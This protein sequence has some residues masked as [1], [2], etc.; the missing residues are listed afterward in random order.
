VAPPRRR[1]RVLKALAIAAG[2]V[3]LVLVLV[4]LGLFPQGWLQR[5]AERQILAALGPGSRIGHLHVIPGRLRAEA[6]DVLIV[7]PG[8]RV[9]VKDARVELALSTLLGRAFALRS[10][11]LRDPRI[12]IEPTPAV[13]GAAAP[14]GTPPP[15]TRP[16]LLGD[17]DVT[18]GQVRYHNPQLGGDIHVEDVRLTGGVGKGALHLQTGT[19][20]WD[21]PH[22]VV[23]E[24]VTATVSITSALVAHLDALEVA[25]RLSHLSAS[26]SLGK[27]TALQPDVEIRLALDIEDAKT[28]APG[29]AM[30][31]QVTGDAHVKG[32]GATLHADANLQGHALTIADR[33]IERARV[34]AVY[35]A[36]GMRADAD[37]E[38]M[39]GRIAATA[40]MNGDQISAD[41][42]GTDLDLHRAAVFAQTPAGA[43][44]GRVSLQASAHG[45]A[46]ERLDTAVNLDASGTD[47]DLAF[48]ARLEAS[49]PIEGSDH[50]LGI[51]WRANG[52]A[53]Q[54]ARPGQPTLQQSTWTADGSANGAWPAVITGQLNGAG[55]FVSATGASAFALDGHG[56]AH[57]ADVAAALDLTGDVGRVHVDVT[58]GAADQRIDVSAQ[59]VALAR[60]VPET[61]GIVDITYHGSGQGAAFHGAGQAQVADLTWRTVHVGA[62][63]ASITSQGD[64]TQVIGDSP[65][66]RL[67]ATAS[68]APPA[69]GRE[70]ALTA[71][72]Q[73][74][75]TPLDQVS[76]FI[77]GERTV[78]GRVRGTLT[79]AAPVKAL[80]DATVQGHIEVLELAADP[81]RGATAHPF[82]LEMS[83]TRLAVRDFSFRGPGVDVETS[84][85]FDFGGRATVDAA[86]DAHLDLSK[87]PLPPGYTMT[88]STQAAVVLSG[89]RDRPQIHGHVD[90]AQLSAAG[91]ALPPF[92]IASARLVLDHDAV[93]LPETVASFARGQVHLAGSAPVAAFWAAPSRA[94]A[95]ARVDVRWDGIDV[96]ALQ[97]TADEPLTGTVDGEAHLQGSWRDP[98][99]A[100]LTLHMPAL[101]LAIGDMP[102]ALTPIDADL[103]ERKLTVAPFEIGSEQGAVR[104]TASADLGRRTIAGSVTGD[105]DLRILSPFM[106]SGSLAGNAQV[107]LSVS[108]PMAAPQTKGHLA[109]HD[110]VVRMREITTPLTD[111]DGT[112]TFDGTRVQIASMEARWGGGPLTLSGSARIDKK[113]LSDMHVEAKGEELAVR[114]QDIQTRVN[115]DLI[116]SGHTGDL[117]LSGSVD[118]ERGLFDRDIFLGQSLRETAA[119]ET[120][121]PFL[122]T[123]GLDLKINTTE[124]FLVRNNLAQVQARGNLRLRGDAQNPAPF[125]TFKIAENG[126]VFIQEREFRIDSGSITYVGSLDPNL[127]IQA[128]TTKPVPWQEGAGSAPR[129][130]EA[131][132]TVHVTGDLARPA[133]ALS[134]DADDLSSTEI[135]S[136]LATGR[137]DPGRDRGAWLVGEQA[138]ELLAG[139]LSR[140]LSRKL[141]SLG[142]DQVTIEPNLIAREQNPGAQFTFG[143]NLTSWSSLVYSLGLDDPEERFFQLNVHPVTNFSVEL[144]RAADNTYTSRVSHVLRIGRP[145]GRGSS[146]SEDRVEVEE[147][148]LQGPIVDQESQI[149]DWLKLKAGDHLSYWDLQKRA[150]RVRRHLVEGGHLEANVIAQLK[151]KRATV[152]VEPGPTYGVKVEG[153]PQAP[154]LTSD[155]RKALYA[156]EA[157]EY[158]EKRLRAAARDRGYL[159]ARVESRVEGTGP[160][161]TL[162]FDVDMGRHY[163]GADVVFPGAKELSRKELLR[164]AGGAG[165]LLA[166]PMHARSG[167]EKHYRQAHFLTAAVRAPQISETAGR[168]KIVVPIDEG[169]QAEITEVSCDGDRLPASSVEALGKNLLGLPPDEQA[170]SDGVQA[171][172]DHYFGLGYPA[173]RVSARLIPHGSDLELHFA[174]DEGDPVVVRNIEFVGSSPIDTDV[175]RRELPVHVGDPLD[176][177]KLT[178]AESRLEKFGL[179]RVSFTSNEAQPDRLLVET[180]PRSRATVNYSLEY[181][182]GTGS[183]VSFD[184][185]A[186]NLT[187]FGLTPGGA[188]AY[189]TNKREMRGWIKLPAFFHR[190]SFSLTGTLETLKLSPDTLQTPIRAA[191]RDNLLQQETHG[192]QLT[193]QVELGGKWQLQ[194]GYEYDHVATRGTPSPSAAVECGPKG[195][196]CDGN[197]GEIKLSLLRDTRDHLLD[198]RRGRFWSVSAAYAPT[199]LG[200]GS[201]FVKV[202]GQ[203][204]AYRA[205]SRNLTWAQAYRVGAG[206]GFHGQAVFLRER[207]SAGGAYSLR[208]FATD[209]VGPRD[210]RS[211]VEL[212]DGVLILNQEL[213]YHHAS[214]L[215]AAVFYDG[216]DV[217][218]KAS[219]IGSSLRHSLGVGLRYESPVGLLRVDLGFPLRPR[220]GEARSQFFFSLGQAF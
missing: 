207:F 113:G 210:A 198:A 151:D 94:P 209:S 111:I 17:V 41:F 184:A 38:A 170:M 36:D 45:R 172:R 138:A 191:P 117:L 30:H 166:D 129:R 171:I 3:T 203:V 195:G 19:V 98:N 72:L 146:R 201:T 150:D 50:R 132:V 163:D 95:D 39:G 97:P 47:G 131:T 211:Q 141:E 102:I 103:R 96:T 1:H 99:A 155:V 18:G 126:R 175:L 80:A 176:P 205:L 84:G 115:A 156:E 120:D 92:Q 31:G 183:G 212:G 199:A 192:V 169:R 133:L 119:A 185:Q 107:D 186:P 196:L 89:T 44:G 78:E 66:L 86:I 28:A 148:S 121:S 145:K 189:D 214:G 22:P 55:K 73:L 152:Y 37:A 21:R 125:G 143:K 71:E 13:P 10:L 54:K 81:L 60:M 109:V 112:L 168:V 69:H 76:A 149:R 164:A 42:H 93:S 77:P 197:V 100:R 35:G 136:L 181:S 122:R 123:L 79:A 65:E 108:G 61:H 206:H 128:T 161:R 70:L 14:A 194:Y 24:P 43:L 2:V 137:P 213:R 62:V 202:Y 118:V 4:A 68:I 178:L 75:D 157:L 180:R 130:R 158:G 142:F 85:A 219:E 9:E 101:A 208:G 88:G 116:L 27:M 190:G 33:P 218:R 25:T 74:Q 159:A 114:Y 106:T 162:T 147:V 160:E 40:T 32:L 53:S 56:Q 167:I 34:H 188:Y 110:G 139:P 82:T 91:A 165:E 87:V 58:H 124:P 48:T 63:T 8:L 182:S 49:G 154:D 187:R 64:K 6:R 215:G 11:E 23:L 57:G 52:T 200:S 193:Q 26:G 173:V 46:A 5:L 144:Q 83:S 134:S 12:T 51:A 127:D 216:G 140:K 217:Y 104:I 15:V 16:V 135:A 29:T 105:A 204:S 7:S 220:A 59:G 179:A 90:F 67:H 174:V 153:M 20:R 177:R